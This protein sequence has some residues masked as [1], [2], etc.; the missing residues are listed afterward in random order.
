VGP[1]RGGSASDVAGPPGLV[2]ALDDLAT[3]RVERAAVRFVLVLRQQPDLA[4]AVL[5][6]IGSRREPALD[7]VRGDALRIVGHGAD[8]ERAY[9]A[10]SAGLEPVAGPARAEAER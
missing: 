5:D 7:V 2:A 4:A 6:A 10:A 3:G 1:G 9:A 8:A